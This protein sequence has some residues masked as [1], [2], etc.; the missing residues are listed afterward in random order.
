MSQQ[1]LQVALVVA[2]V[3]VA[4][5]ACDG[6]DELGGAGAGPV[7]P[8]PFAE[9]SAPA[10]ENS[11]TPRLASRAGRM[12]LSWQ[13]AGAGD[14]A[15]VRFAM[16]RGRRW[17]PARTVVSSPT[18]F[19]NWA[20]YPSVVPLA[21]DSLAA[22]WLQYNGPGT[23][24]YQ[25]RLAVS[26]DAGA[27]W[28][29][30]LIPHETKTE[31]EHGFVTLLPV[32]GGLEVFWLDG[33]AYEGGA[34]QMSLR[35]TRVGTDG[36]RGPEVVL[37]E[38]TCDCCQTGV[39]ALG[40]TLIVVYRGR[41]NGEIRDIEVVRR[42]DGEWTSPVRVH[43]DGWRIEACPVNGPAIAAAEGQVMVAWFTAAGGEARVLGAMST[44]GGA[45]FGPA[46]TLDEGRP[47]G[48]VAAI[49]L[50]DGGV[51]VGWVEAL[52][53]DDGGAEVRVRLIDREGAVSPSTSVVRGAAARA[54]GFP[55]L[56]EL[57]GDLFVAWTDADAN[58]VRLARGTIP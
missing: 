47:I 13:A 50:D 38:R 55:S 2:A 5:V 26:H 21:G 46:F 8:G 16:L 27:S 29:L 24:A 18:L 28:S 48:R 51:A 43:R 20:D 11:R 33:R 32:P 4:S 9:M 44:D 6:L 25:V 56:A 10:G 53:A 15:H 30:P 34:Q 45:S 39:A 23:Y 31:T 49:P 52:E 14:T 41:S 35:N 36:R 1:G 3:S 57:D 58:V 17:T 37:D 54:S 42:V 22:H 12:I 19:V 7:P 40:D